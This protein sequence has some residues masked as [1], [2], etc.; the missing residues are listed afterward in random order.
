MTDTSR[1]AQLRRAFK[2]QYGYKPVGISESELKRI[3]TDRSIER[4][5]DP[6]HIFDHMW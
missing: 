3:L 1:L 5:G 2:Q 4:Y 6:N